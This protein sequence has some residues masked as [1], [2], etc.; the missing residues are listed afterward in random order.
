V[1]VNTAGSSIVVAAAPPN[2]F[3]YSNCYWNLMGNGNVTAGVNFLG[4]VAGELAPLEFRVNNNRSLLHVFTAANA[5]PNLIGGYRG[6]IVTG[7][8]GTIGGGGQQAGINRVSA[9][10]GTVS[11]GHSNVVQGL[12]TSGFIGG[13]ATNQIVGP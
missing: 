13:G 11:G 1:T 8:G 3:T 2:C 4:T 9:D 7:T 12:S 10:W 5:S 6:N